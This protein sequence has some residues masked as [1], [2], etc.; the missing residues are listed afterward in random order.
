MVGENISP[1]NLQISWVSRES[2]GSSHDAGTLRNKMVLQKER[3]DTLQKLLVPCDEWEEHA[4]LLL[5]WSNIKTIFYI[6]NMTP[7]MVVHDVM[8]EE[9]YSEK[10]LDFSP[11]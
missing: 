1:M 7:T 3:I 6:M 11:P 10:K 2:R 9:N 5:G 8:H 4:S